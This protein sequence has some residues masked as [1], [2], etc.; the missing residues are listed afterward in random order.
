MSNLTPAQLQMNAILADLQTLVSSGDLNSVI[1]DDMSKIS[2]LDRTWPGFP[3]A[4]VIPPIISGN[5]FE[6]QAN[7]VMEYTW[8]V[9]VVTTPENLPST[10]PTYLAG[11][12]DK[13]VNVFNMDATLQGTANA[14]VYPTIVEPPGPVSSNSVTYVVFYIQFKAKQLVPAGI[15]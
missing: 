13:I 8:Y 15:Q 11:L 1:A 9:M 6:D 3:S 4:V 12:E 10:D 2:P 14:A 5:E 7:N